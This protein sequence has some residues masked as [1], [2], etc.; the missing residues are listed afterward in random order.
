MDFLAVWLTRIYNA[1][2]LVPRWL[3]F[4]LSGSVASVVINFLHKSSAPKASPQTQEK[5]RVSIDTP[6]TDTPVERS[7]SAIASP[8]QAGKRKRAKAKK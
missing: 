4:V 6:S 1:V 5:P 2:I 3:L 8:S 7:S